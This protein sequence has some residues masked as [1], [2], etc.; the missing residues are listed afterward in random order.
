MV[1][2]EFRYSGCAP[3]NQEAQ[4]PTSRANVDKSTLPPDT[5]ATTRPMTAGGHL[6][7]ERGGDRARSR[8][9]GDHVQPFRDDAHRVAASSSVTTIESLTCSR[10]SGHIVETT[11]FPPAPSTN[12]A[13]HSS[14]RLAFPA[15]RERDSG[16]AVS[17]SAA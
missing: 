12:D 11:D 15:L 1:E 10:N 16:A 9:F 17:G 14:N 4:A 2:N 13:F 5:T 8:P 6:R 7:R 3:S